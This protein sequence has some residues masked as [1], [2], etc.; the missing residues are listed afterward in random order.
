MILNAN[1]ATKQSEN[2]SEAK[3]KFSARLKKMMK[4]H[5]VF[6]LEVI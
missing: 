5:T 3:I 6:I 1:Q 2:Q 4:V